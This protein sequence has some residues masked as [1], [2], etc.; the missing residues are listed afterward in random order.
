MAGVQTAYQYGYDE[1]GELLEK[2][3]QHGYVYSGRQGWVLKMGAESID[4]AE[5]FKLFCLP[6]ANA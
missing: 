6:S 3:A 2:L 1:L 5:L 4:L